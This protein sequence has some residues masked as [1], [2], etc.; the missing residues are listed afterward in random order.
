MKKSTQYPPTP[1][2]ESDQGTL[3]VRMPSG[4]QSI[5]GVEAYMLGAYIS[6]A[7]RASIDSGNQSRGVGILRQCSN[8]CT[9]I[10]TL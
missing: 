10:I 9:K 3:E 5:C 1:T 7:D 4:G 8:R 6:E 2:S